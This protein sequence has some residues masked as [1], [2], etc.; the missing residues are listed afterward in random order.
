MKHGIKV[1]KDGLTAVVTLENGNEVRI[2][3]HDPMGVDG[4]AVLIS[5]NLGGPMHVLPSS[6]NAIVISTEKALKLQERLITE[7]VEERRRRTGH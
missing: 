1:D 4:L 6:G 5:T 7:A 2:Q 3:F